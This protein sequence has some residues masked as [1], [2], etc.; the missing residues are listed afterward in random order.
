MS[1]PI[2]VMTS[3]PLITEVPSMRKITLL[4]LSRKSMSIPILAMDVLL[5]DH[6]NAI[7][8]KI[9]TPLCLS[10]KSMS[11]LISAMDSAPFRLQKRH[12]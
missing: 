11:I 8:E 3:A 6:R 4:V 1:I 2:S 5:L 9:V 12:L 10:I 7:Y